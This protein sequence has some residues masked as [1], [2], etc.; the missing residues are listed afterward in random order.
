MSRAS[1]A[2]PS[3]RNMRGAMPSQHPRPTPIASP[4]S[5]HCIYVGRF[6]C[7]CVSTGSTAPNRCAI[8]ATVPPKKT[9]AMSEIRLPH[10]ADAIVESAIFCP[11]KSSIASPARIMIPLSVMP[12]PMKG[13]MPANATCM[14]SA[15]VGMA[16]TPFVTAPSRMLMRAKLTAISVTPKFNA[17]CTPT[18]MTCCSSSETRTLLERASTQKARSSFEYRI[19]TSAPHL[20]PRARVALR[21]WA[22]HDHLSNACAT[23]SVSAEIFDIMA[24]S[25][26]GPPPEERARAMRST[27]S[28]P[29]DERRSSG[30]QTWEDDTPSRPHPAGSSSGFGNGCLACTPTSDSASAAISSHSAPRI[31][32]IP[33]P[34]TKSAPTR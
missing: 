33:A 4:Q 15:R 23:T 25:T 17:S 20:P 30:S 16:T 34:G 19:I 6:F 7:A 10:A 26:T 3:S 8:C 9:P 21:A 22:L 13:I 32:P 2:R 18:R 11:M 5:F 31:A 12:N 1:G 27:R 24:T 29:S 28:A 14:S